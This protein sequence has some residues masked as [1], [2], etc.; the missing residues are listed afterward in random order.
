MK[1]K[2]AN[3]ELKKIGWSWDYDQLQSIQTSV[4]NHTGEQISLE[5]ID[6]LLNLI[7]QSDTK[8][9]WFCEGCGGLVGVTMA[10]KNVTVN[11]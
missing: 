10:R 5:Q 3:A 11:I 6:T 2:R 9:Q 8:L 4:N 1:L 7:S